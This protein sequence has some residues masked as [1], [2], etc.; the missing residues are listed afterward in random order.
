V[1]S[2]EQLDQLSVISYQ[3]FHWSLV[4]DYLLMLFFT[5]FGLDRLVDVGSGQGGKY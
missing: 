4:T 1:L 2:T 5:V 3:F